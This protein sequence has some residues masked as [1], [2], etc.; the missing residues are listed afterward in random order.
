MT[1]FALAMVFAIG[2]F[3]LAVCEKDDNVQ[4]ST[5]GGVDITTMATPNGERL[6][7]AE[8]GPIR[9][10]L[11][12]PEVDT[13]AFRLTVRGLVEKPFSLTWEEIKIWYSV[14]TDTMLMYCVEGWEVWGQWKGIKV[15]DLLNN[16]SPA[17]TATHVLFRT[18]DGYS[19]SIP[20][21]YIDKYDPILAYE[22]NGKPLQQHDGFPLRLVVFGLFGYKWAKW[23]N[24]I[25]LIDKATLGYWEKRGYSD[26]AI[27]PLE[28]RQYYEGKDAEKVTF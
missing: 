9:S 28:R 13:S 18:V 16:A 26:Q 22:V 14:T 4:N 11:G 27:V 19:T 1:K 8:F 6:K 5:P 17:K 25:E 21:T 15:K 3:Y 7:P 23:V 10:A 24:D 12:E 20:L 2:L